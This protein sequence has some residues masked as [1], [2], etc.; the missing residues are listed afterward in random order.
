M[1]SKTLPFQLEQLPF[2]KFPNS[3]Q[4]FLNIEIQI[5][6]RL[7]IIRYD[8]RTCIKPDFKLINIFHNALPNDNIA[9]DRMKVENTRK[10]SNAI[11]IN[12]EEIK[13]FSPDLIIMAAPYAYFDKIY[14][15]IN[16][17]CSEVLHP[18]FI[19]DQCGIILTTSKVSMGEFKNYLKMNIEKLGLNS[20]NDLPSLDLSDWSSDWFPTFVSSK[21]FKLF[22][23]DLRLSE[24]FRLRHFFGLSQSFQLFVLLLPLVELRQLSFIVL[25]VV[26][27]SGSGLSFI[28]LNL[29]EDNGPQ[30]LVFL[31]FGFIFFADGQ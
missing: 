8:R 18:K 11:K 29:F 21:S 16:E 24:D 3:Y 1:A 19:D 14:N 15:Q 27:R 9:D 12:V 13:K 28:E 23:V 20:R 17:Q 10:E 5:E 30:F 4:N 25:I 7:K 6:W 26:R 31:N 22:L 2:Q